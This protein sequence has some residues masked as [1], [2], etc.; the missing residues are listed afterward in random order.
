MIYDTY[1][2]IYS[3]YTDILPKWEIISAKNI[4]LCENVYCCCNNSPLADCR[5]LCRK[6]RIRGWTGFV[7]RTA[8]STWHIAVHRADSRRATL[9]E[10]ISWSWESF[11]REMEYFW[12]SYLNHFKHTET[13]RFLEFP[14]SVFHRS[15]RNEKKW[16]NLSWEIP[17]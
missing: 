2:R 10:T 14:P 7:P 17:P 13:R 5:I 9:P 4:N 11:H 3:V 6:Q 8:K 16:K 1:N 12:R 15:G